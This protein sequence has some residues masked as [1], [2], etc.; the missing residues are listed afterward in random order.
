[1]SKHHSMEEYCYC[2]HEVEYGHDWSDFDPSRQYVACPLFEDESLE[3]TYTLGELIQ[4]APNG[5]NDRE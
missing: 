4:M 2:D 3:C 1:M 5:K